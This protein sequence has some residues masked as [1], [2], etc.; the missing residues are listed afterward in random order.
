MLYLKKYLEDKKVREGL[1]S[2]QQDELDSI[3][4]PLDIL[5][6]YE[7]R[8]EKNLLMNRYALQYIQKKMIDFYVIPQDDSS[9][10]GYTSLDQKTVLEDI[11][12]EHLQLQTMAY[13]GAYEVAMSLIT[14]AYNDY[15]QRCP[16]IYPFYA[17]ILGPTIVPKY[18]DK[19]MY[20]T[21]KS[22]VRVTGAKLTNN[23]QEADLILAINCPGKFM[24]ESFDNQKDVTYSSYR[25]LLTFSY[26]IKDYLDQ[27]YQVALCDSAYSNGGNLELLFFR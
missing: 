23:T 21:L 13:P 26:Q 6:D 4:I 12:K 14:R 8:R 11:R 2:S 27:G 1:Q 22:H 16:H 18:E 20:E 25:E 24:Q 19:P 5:K 17:S 9:I 3:Y 7:D 15:Y 10:F